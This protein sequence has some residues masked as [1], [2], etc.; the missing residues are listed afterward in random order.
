MALQQQTASI[1]RNASLREWWSV[2]TILLLA[3]VF[4]E[5]VF[6]GAIL[7][8]ADWARTAHRL[9]AAILIALTLTAGLAAIVTLRHVTHG[10]R[11]GLILLSLTASIFLQAAIGVL[12]A[13]GANLLW[14][15]V[16]LGVALFGF[17]VR[18]VVT[19][20]RIGGS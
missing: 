14:I 1:E 15:H 18:A 8:G 7:S 4:T 13:K 20:R 5:A 10:R 3:A 2:I 16:P 6:A 11:L 17:A 12:S 19:A 9:N